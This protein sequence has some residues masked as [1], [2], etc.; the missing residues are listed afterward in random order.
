MIPRRTFLGCLAGGLL[1]APLAA[2]AE[3]TLA[4]VG[5][6]ASGSPRS[7]PLVADFEERLRELGYIEGRNL[8]IEFRSAEGNVDRL[9]TLAAELV[10]LKANVIFTATAPGVRAVKAASSSMPIVTLATD[11]DPI[12]AGF[13]S[14]LG[15]PGGNVT[16]L[17]LRQ[18]EL[19]AKRL[20]LL[21]EALPATTRVAVF[22][23]T[24][25]TDQLRTAEATARSLGLQLQPLELRSPPYDYAS[26][27][28]KAA[29]GHAET[30]L[31]LAF[32]LMYRDRNEV[33]AAVLKTRLPGMFP[34]REVAEAGGLMAYGANL[35]EMYR[36]A[37]VYVVKI[38]KG[39]KAADLPVE[40]PTKFELVLNLKTA[41]ALGLTIPPSLLQRADQV[42]E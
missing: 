30:L 17:F 16:G 23:D 3:Q 40:R 34:F 14:G 36:S 19:T 37:A 39:A 27:L 42:I 26:A 11:Y 31:G 35:S 38:L 15:R 41:K 8:T 22:W 18:V 33:A 9:P 5:F 20:S 12:A 25:A 32:P 6:P 4:R 29:R 7:V 10:Q 13:V 2:E 28:E 21:K 24:F 1:A